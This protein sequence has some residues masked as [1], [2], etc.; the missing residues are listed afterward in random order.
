M[1]VWTLSRSMELF[2]KTYVIVLRTKCTAWR[3]FECISVLIFR[4]KQSRIGKIHVLVPHIAIF[5]TLNMSTEI[6]SNF[7][8]KTTTWSNQDY[9]F[10]N[11]CVCKFFS[12]LL[13]N[14]VLKRLFTDLGKKT[15]WK[16]ANKCVYG[17]VNHFNKF[18]FQL[19]S[20]TFYV[21]P[22]LLVWPHN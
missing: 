15:G 19:M 11:I 3:L 7:V 9:V 14:I 5:F 6:Y 1:V 12:M 16:R 21:L 17:L 8:H 2:I 20:K 18:V 4:A 13:K 22:F 10:V